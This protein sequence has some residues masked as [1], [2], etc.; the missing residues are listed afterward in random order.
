LRPFKATL[1]V[2]RPDGSLQQLLAGMIRM[3]L[4]AFVTWR[5]TAIGACWRGKSRRFATW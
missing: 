3:W 2:R 5:L 1:P 4:D